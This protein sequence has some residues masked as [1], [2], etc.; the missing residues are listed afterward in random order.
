MAPAIQS[1]LGKVGV[2]V[3]LDPLSSTAWSAALDSSKPDYA[4][5]LQSGGSTGL[6]PTH[7]SVF[8]NCKNPVDSYYRNC[9]LTNLYAKGVSASNPAQQTATYNKAALIINQ[10]A[11]M[12][13]LWLND[14]LDVVSSKVGGAFAIYSNDRDSLF[15]IARWTLAS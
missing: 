3:T 13:A 14:N 7:S 6:G 2:K 15:Q 4:F 8:F 10:A 11:P 1:Y 12:P 5:S 9:T